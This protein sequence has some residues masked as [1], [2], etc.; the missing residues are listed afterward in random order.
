[1]AGLGVLCISTKKARGVTGSGAPVG[2]PFDIDYVAHEIGHQFGCNHTFNG[3]A[4]SCGGGNRNNSTAVEPGSGST[5]MAYAGICSPQNI[6][7]NSD[8]HFSFISIQEANIR[9]L[10]GTSCAVTT[11]NG[12][13]APIVNAGLDYTIPKG[14]AFILKGAATDTNND[15]LT[16]CWEQTNNDISLQPPVAAATVGPNFRSL[17]PD[18]YFP[19]IQ[20]VVNNNLAPT[21]EVVPNVER[22][23]NF[24]L[25]VRNNRTPNG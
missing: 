8:S 21:W 13:A 23:M 7:A 22:S 16:Y 20:D 3:D 2:D 17:S 19:K 10:L 18:R 25:T 24:A 12:N 4:G 9:T 15:A 1:L 14:T 11:A 5:I 6:Q